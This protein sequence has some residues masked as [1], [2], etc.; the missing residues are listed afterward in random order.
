MKASK[1]L[2]VFFCILLVDGLASGQPAHEGSD[3]KPDS[4]PDGFRD[5]KW[6]TDISTLKDMALVMSID[7]DTK[8]YKRN[9]DVLR[10]GDVNLSYIHSCLSKINIEKE[11]VLN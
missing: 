6:G 8:R 10:M 1:I 5:I 3:F 11:K 4:E 2:I 9:G 7:K